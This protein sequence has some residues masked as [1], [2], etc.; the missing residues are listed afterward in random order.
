MQE[1]RPLLVWWLTGSAALL[2]VLIAFAGY[3]VVSSASSFIHPMWGCLPGDF[4]RPAHVAIAE[5]DQRFDSLPLHATVDCRMRLG[6]PASFNSIY[7]FYYKQLS[8]GDWTWTAIL[9]SEQTGGATM[10]FTRRSRPDTHGSV[11]IHKQTGGTPF[12]IE[13]IS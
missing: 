11:T 13:L 9:G 12:E 1:R 5:I 10:A 2:V 4:P 7:D 3:F 8:A 6:S